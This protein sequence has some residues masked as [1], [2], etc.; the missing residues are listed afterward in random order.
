VERYRASAHDE[1]GCVWIRWPLILA[2]GT[3]DVGDSRIQ[4]PTDASDNLLLTNRKIV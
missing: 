1:I 2:A 4:G 3:L